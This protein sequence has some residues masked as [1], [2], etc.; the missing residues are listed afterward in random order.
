MKDTEVN[1]LFVSGGTEIVA[2]SPEAL[3]ALNRRGYDTWGA[4]IRKLGI[5]LD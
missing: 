3:G 2:S 5:K 1:A 4:I